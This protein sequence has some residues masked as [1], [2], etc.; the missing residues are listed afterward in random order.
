[1]LGYA[2]LQSG[3]FTSFAVPA[4]TAMFVR[5][6]LDLTGAAGETSTMR[7]VVPRGRRGF[8]YGVVALAASLPTLA[9]QAPAAD[10]DASAVQEVVVTGSRIAAPNLTSTS[11]IQVVTGRELQQG[12]KTDVIDLLNQLPQ[13]FQNSATDFSNTST[14]LATPGG[15][16]TADL[17]G[18]GPQ[19]TL[20]LVNG[21]RLGVGDPNTANPNPAPDLDQIPAA[22]IE[23]I[24][25]VTGGASAVYGSDALA[26]VVN[27]ILRR[28]FTGVE[29]DGQ[30][31]EYWH[32]NHQGWVQGLQAQAGQGV[33]S[34][35]RKDGQN[36]NFT[37]VLGS[38]VADGKGNVTGYLTYLKAEPISGFQR[39]FGGCQLVL[40][41]AR[42]AV[43]CTGSQNSNLFG[44]GS[45]DQY[46]VVGSQFLPW[47]QADSIPPPFFNSQPYIYMSRGDQRYNGGFLAHVDI[48]DHVKPY[49]ELGFMDD[50]THIAIAPSGLFQSNPLDTTGN[51]NFNINCS[52]P[53]LSAQE[54]EILC[55]PA[56]IAADAAD[57]GSVSAN[58]NIGRRNIEGGGRLSFWEH[59]NYRGVFGITGDIGTGWSYDAYGSYYYTSLFNRES[60]FLDFSKV[61]NALQ[62]TGTA[63]NPVCISG[64]PCVPWNLFTQG[65]VSNAALQYLYSP[66]TSFGIS[67]ER[68]LHADVTGDLGRIGLR[69]PLASDGIGVNMGIEHRNDAL[70]FAPDEAELSGLLSGLGGASS[71]VDNSESVTEEFI[72]VR[73]PLVQD[74]P[75]IESLV[76]DGGFRHSNYN[77]SGGV[78]TYKFEVQYS[79]LGDVRIRAGY[80]RAIRAP[81]VLEFFAPPSFGL[82]GAP[83]V[84]P[85]APTRDPATGALIPAS[86]SLAQCEHTGVTP[87]QYGNGGTTNT[88][89]QCT[90]LQCG[91]VQ[92]GNLNLKPEQGDSV[93][94]GVTLTPGALPGFSASLDYWQIKLKDV[95]GTVPATI[96]LQTCLQSGDPLYCNLISRTP[97]GSIS[98]SSVASG[99][100]ISQTGINIGA[101]EVSGI[102]VQAAYRLVLAKLGAVNF[103]LAGSDFLKST[104]TPYPGAHTYDCAGLFGPT[105]LNVSPRWRHNLRATWTTPWDWEL[106]AQWRYI[107]GVKLDSNTSDPTLSDGKYDAFDARMPAVSYLDLSASWTVLQGLELRA[108]VNNLFDKDPPIVSSN[109]AASG[110]ANSFPTYDQL[111]RQLF[112]AF[113]AKF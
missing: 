71:A 28:D 49:A 59:T 25:V 97:G 51:G 67:T 19:R 12:G 20:V 45:T 95:I 94:L 5:T 56:Q 81:N 69:S 24:D 64:P 72:E 106:S 110:A 37:L 17:R 82:I 76:A 61:D 38:N 23:R 99:G 22:L 36:R 18:I 100:Y 62:V 6:A 13:N 70:S 39:D 88:I 42:N 1:M 93:S 21:R 14:G 10:S 16:S 44:V 47:P 26:G 73:A 31:G 107:G 79:P 53:L 34:G 74:R 90:A 83:G 41:A 48:N 89:K 80:Q 101:A 111:G 60:N 29:L 15:I 109:V 78:N 105:C 84:D 52:N 85:C 104:S 77:P 91:Q 55:T 108:G 3:D 43:V 112:V 32:D 40:N 35:S 87:G 30:L 9:Q 2:A 54:A 57:P 50:Q 103:Q 27:F 113:T 68:I 65:K 58:V 66:G 92:G 102:D 33:V 98:G 96:I 75:G 86:A 63:A 11:P 46:S 4:I 8:L 7:S